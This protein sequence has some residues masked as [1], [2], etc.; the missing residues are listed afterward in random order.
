MRSFKFNVGDLLKVCEGT[1]CI[2]SPSG[3]QYFDSLRVE[4]RFCDGMNNLYVVSAEDGIGL[5]I[6]ED[7]GIELQEASADAVPGMAPEPEEE[8]ERYSLTR[9]EMLEFAE[10]MTF[11]LDDRLVPFSRETLRSEAWL[12]GYSFAKAHK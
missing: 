4:F 10:K 7:N 8:G 5:V 1:G 11:H 2:M 6:V 9:E 3:K 12:L